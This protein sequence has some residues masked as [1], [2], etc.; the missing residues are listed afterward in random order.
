MRCALSPPRPQLC[1]K[2]P[3]SSLV[4][5]L[6]APFIALRPFLSHAAPQPRS[7]PITRRPSST[8]PQTR[9]GPPRS[10]P[11]TSAPPKRSAALSRQRP[12]LSARESRPRKRGIARLRPG[13]G[14]GAGARAG[15]RRRVHQGGAVC[16]VAPGRARARMRVRAHVHT[17]NTHTREPHRQPARWARSLSRRRRSRH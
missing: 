5:L 13:R 1:D 11:C 8:P 15:Q 3:Q 17:R 12:L 7:A 6:S 14:A 4:Y 16:R 9:R 10:S 2:H